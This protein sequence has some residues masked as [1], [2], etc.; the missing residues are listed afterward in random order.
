M[1]PKNKSLTPFAM[2][3][4]FHEIYGLPIADTPGH[5]SPEEIKLREDL[6]SEE[7]W[8]YDRAVAKNDLVEIAD[9]LCD[10][11][12]IILGTCL[13]YGLPFDE[14]FMEVHRS[15]LSKLDDG[16]SILREDGKV[17]KGKNYSPPDIG[18]IINGKTENTNT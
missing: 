16:K 17:L 11:V 18:A 10:M 4:E 13:V 8:E 12:Y 3:R 6:L 5:P 9:A 1:S 2:V 15:N 7:Y 14:I